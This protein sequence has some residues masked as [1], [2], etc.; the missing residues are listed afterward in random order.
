MDAAVSCMATL[1][2]GQRHEESDS[3]SQRARVRADELGFPYPPL[4]TPAATPSAHMP[5]A[6][7]ERFALGHRICHSP[8]PGSIVSSKR[9]YGPHGSSRLQAA[10]VEHVKSKVGSSFMTTAF[11]DLK[12]VPC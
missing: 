9:G 4:S 3:P 8:V 11:I 6:D 2:D 7:A 1:P 12:Q 5:P 10:G